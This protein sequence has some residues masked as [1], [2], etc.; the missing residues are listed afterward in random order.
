MGYKSRTPTALTLTGQS[1]LTSPNQCYARLQRLFIAQF[2]LQMAA[3][4]CARGLI[5]CCFKVTDA[6]E[7]FE[8]HN[9]HAA[10]I[11]RALPLGM[12][13]RNTAYSKQS[14]PSP[15]K[16]P[17]NCCKSTTRQES[18]S[19]EENK[20]GFF[21]C[22]VAVHRQIE[23]FCARVSCTWLTHGLQVTH[24]DS[25]DIDGTKS[26]DFSKPMLCTASTSLHCTI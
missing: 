5:P 11:M 23:L 26:F 20:V 13:L 24:S 6:V 2:R 7:C 9:E 16:S 12:H 25:L 10:T 18:S 1:H 21:V 17:L 8:T 14:C 15:L 4:P 22:F 3:L 19:G